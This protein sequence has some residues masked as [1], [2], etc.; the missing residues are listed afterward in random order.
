M[1]P[2]P[3]TILIVDD[4]PEI[5]NLLTEVL[6]MDGYNVVGTSRPEQALALIESTPSLKL[7]LSDITMPNMNG[8]EL[9]RRMCVSRPELRTVFMTGEA[10]EIMFRKADP[11]LYKPFNIATLR[12]IV[13]VTLAETRSYSPGA[14]AGPERRRRLAG[15]A[16]T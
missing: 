6:E 13:R 14:W 7:I 16:Q 1:S 4:E 8:V 9:I 3:A 5:V 11:V 10:G 2:G 12:E 15:A